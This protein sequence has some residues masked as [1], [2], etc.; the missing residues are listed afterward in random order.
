MTGGQYNVV[1]SLEAVLRGL[2]EFDAEWDL[3]DVR[4]H[5]GNISDRLESAITGVRSLLASH[6]WRP[7]SEPPEVTR[8]LWEF[9]APRGL[10]WDVLSAVVWTPYKAPCWTHYRRFVAPGEA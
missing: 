7:M 4:D 2:S 3:D 1:E 6:R 8:G 5:L 10:T 9:I